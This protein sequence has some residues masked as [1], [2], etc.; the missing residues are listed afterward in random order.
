MHIDGKLMNKMSNRASPP[1]KIFDL[2]PPGTAV[3]GRVLVVHSR[4]KD[5]LSRARAD[6]AAQVGYPSNDNH[7]P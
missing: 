7:C 3:R 2:A 6:V 1:I 5:A 4:A